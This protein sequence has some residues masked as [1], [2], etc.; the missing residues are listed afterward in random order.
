MSFVGL[1]PP[2][3]TMPV[4]KSLV[5]SC[6]P[7]EFFGSLPDSDCCCWCGR[8]VREDDDADDLL[9]RAVD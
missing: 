1:D 8:C 2:S 3:V 4:C 5:S 9:L 7:T 6:S